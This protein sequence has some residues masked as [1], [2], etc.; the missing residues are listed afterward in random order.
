MAIIGAHVSAAVS[1]ERSFDKAL[2]IGADCT[3]IFISPPQQWFQ[4]KHNDA[5]IERY[6]I[7]SRESGIKHNYIHATYL[8]NLGTKNPEH[9][10]K[11]IDWLIYS[12]HMAYKMG[13]TGVIFHTGSHKGEGFET[14]L[15]QVVEN[16]K[17]VLDK[18]P[19]HTSLRGVSTTKQSTSNKIAMPASWRARNDGNL[20]Y[21]ILENTA[22]AGGTIGRSF[23]ELGEIL[24]QVQDDRLRICLDTQHAFAAGY[25]LKTML[26]LK[27]MLTEFD[28]EIGLEKLAVIHC[29]DSKT[30]HKSLRDRHENIG[31]GLIGKEA[32]KNMLNHPKLKSLPFILEVPGFSGN[33]PDE[34]NLKLLKSLVKS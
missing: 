5:E 6:K 3:Q 29:N 22:G 13:V 8:I 2:E 21:L 9:L 23:S 27:D 25:D 10:Q 1:L 31:E 11:S 4:T 32:F 26:G 28:E 15:T 12:L 14:V 20:P 30:A 18:S 19:I 33:G 24:K 16:I 17:T 34:Q 7:Q